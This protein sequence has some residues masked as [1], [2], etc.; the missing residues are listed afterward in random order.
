MDSYAQNHEDEI[1][2]HFF[3]GSDR[4]T[5]IDVGAHDGRQFSNTFLLEQCGW[6]GL[7][8][9]PNPVS[10]Q[11]LVK[12]RPDSICVN[13][14]CIDTPEEK[15]LELL[16]PNGY[17]VLGV[18][19][20]AYDPEAIA[21]ILGIQPSQIT[22]RSIIVNCA[23][24]DI[25]I[26]DYLGTRIPIDLVSIDTEGTE[27]QVLAGFDVARFH[28]TVL[29]VEANDKQ[30]AKELEIY[31]KAFQYMLAGRVAVNLFFVLPHNLGRM[32]T[33]LEGTA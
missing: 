11:K 25:I 20:R 18:L 8:I 9:E 23:P 14:A 6:H 22:T 16:I 17:D 15:T 32:K 30:A 13:L 19:R 28:P 2:V 1:L 24:L 12:N 5:F 31:L 27:L 3:G 33:C 21:R 26:I 4:G 10:F 29:V 7:C